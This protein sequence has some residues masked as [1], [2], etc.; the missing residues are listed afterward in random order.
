VA[1]VAMV[2]LDL[3][4]AEESVCPKVSMWPDLVGTCSVAQKLVICMANLSEC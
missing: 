3:S 1:C 4:S 2:I